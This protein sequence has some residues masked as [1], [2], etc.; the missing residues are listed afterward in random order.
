MDTT[1]VASAEGAITSDL[2]Q[3]QLLPWIGSAFLIASTV[4]AASSGNLAKSFGLK[5]SFAGLNF[6]FIVGCAI[7][8]ASSSILMLIIGRAIAGLGAGGIFMTATTAIWTLSAVLGPLIGGA[9]A[10]H[11]L[12]RWCFYINLPICL[13]ATPIAVIALWNTETPQNSLHKKI[14]GL[15]FIGYAVV[16]IGLVCLVT[17]MQ[18]GGISWAWNSAQV[19]ILL[20]LAVLLVSLKGNGVG[21]ALVG[22]IQNNLSS[23]RINESTALLEILQS[24]I[25]VGIDSTQLV[26]IR[27]ILADPQYQLAQASEALAE[28]IDAYNFGFSISMRVVIAFGVLALASVSFMREE[29]IVTVTWEN[30]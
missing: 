10:D 23:I 13:L 24:P 9:F 22:A 16:V 14:M 1:I 4:S 28:L 19:V 11:G 27:V 7:C 20:I 17:A 6:F 29:K 26:E 15:D 2:G 18:E 25:F 21:V 12:W 8:G 5:W 3:E 30:V